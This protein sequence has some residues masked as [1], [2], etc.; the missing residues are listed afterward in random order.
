M[1]QRF[2]TRSFLALLAC[3][4][5]FAAAGCSD[6]AAELEANLSGGK[7]A[8]VAGDPGEAV[9]LFKEALRIDPNSVDAHYGLARAYLDGQ[10]L[11]QALWELDE[12]VRLDP[13][14]YPA[15]IH[16]A[17]LL[18]FGDIEAQEAAVEHAQRVLDAE[19]LA[20]DDPK[21]WV[22]LLA[23]GRAL[24]A[25]G[26]AGEAKTTLVEAVELAP[27]E[28]APLFVLAQM[29]E[30]EGERATAEAHYRKLAELE[31]GFDSTMILARFLSRDRAGDAEAEA[32]H[33]GAV[34]S[35][36]PGE[37]VRA[38]QALAGFLFARG[39]GREAAE[40]LEAGLQERENDPQLIRSLAGI[41]HASGDLEKAEATLARAAAAAP[42]N[43]PG[44][45]L[46]LAD[47]RRTRGDLDGALEAIE[48]AL[49]KGA[50]SEAR[51]RKAELLIQS[52]YAGGDASLRARGRA[53]ID[54]E[55]ARD[56]GQPEARLV[57]GWLE[58]AEG[59]ADEA[60]SSA[61][62]VLDRQPEW[63]RAHVL[64]GRS[65]E[66][67][68]RIPAA[69]AEYERALQLEP[70][71]LETRHWLATLLLRTG[72]AEA[73]LEHAR[74][75]LRG[76]PD[77]HAARLLVADA[78][79]AT[80]RR[81]EAARE[82][83]SI[84]SSGRGAE[85]LYAQGQLQAAGGDLEGGRKTL[86]QSLALKPNDPEILIAL[87]EI[88]QRTGRANDSMVRVKAALEAV[89][90]DAR[91]HRLAGRA[92]MVLG[93]NEE[94]ERRLAKAIELNPQDLR[95]YGVLTQFML[96]SGRS[97][98]IVGNYERAAAANPDVGVLRVTL[99]RLYE[100]TGREDEAIERYREALRLDPELAVAQNNLAWLLAERGE[101]LDFALDLAQEAKARLPN[102]PETADTL[103]WVLLKKG[104]PSAAIGYFQES[105][106]LIHP[107]H[108]AATLVRLHLA[109]ALQANGE[110]EKARSVV[111]EALEN[112]PEALA[113]SET[114]R[115]LR[116]LQDTLSK[117]SE[118]S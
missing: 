98:E 57:R 55:L 7:A 47:F 43:A 25:L 21:R 41:H 40:V 42:E 116:V 69:Q 13:D 71:S 75:V 64:L 5:T 90:N 24:Q 1:P 63:A 59:R 78:L 73:A 6:P 26:R 36:A 83:G 91:L 115:E 38:Y 86:L 45:A 22:A 88:D 15:R 61:R 70:S 33:R 96:E 9:R 18:R 4:G 118:T 17:R 105:L 97:D 87:F 28:G 31:P 110:V 82:I 74:A 67:L 27:E 14:H 89:P 30:A 58:L 3:L 66:A 95:S 76:N 10:R 53:I 107:D 56:E 94:A 11:Q 84:P 52:S 68:G 81:E 103:G 117:P 85:A 114:A 50:G 19:T 49:E 51:I 35:A 101:E 29:L 2:R 12:T 106:S 34:E 16:L 37:K 92:A 109:L 46:Q 54:A 79:L 100:A 112:A 20:E 108:P 113:E 80:G 65:L 104:I 93:R 102:F 32:L 77:A 111:D 72:Q 62:R 8:L 39:Q 48:E 99:A 44:P 60:A 23:K